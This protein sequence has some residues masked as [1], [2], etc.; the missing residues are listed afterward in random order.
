MM[1]P[2]YGDDE[3][4]RKPFTSH[5]KQKCPGAP[6]KLKRNR[7]RGSRLLENENPSPVQPTSPT[8]SAFRSSTTRPI[9]RSLLDELNE[10]DHPEPA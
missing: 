5:Q 3:D 2:E 7:T 4:D 10:S 9:R 6:V 1:T 8:T